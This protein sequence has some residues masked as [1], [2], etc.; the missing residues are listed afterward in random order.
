MKLDEKLTR[1]KYLRDDYRRLEAEAK[2]LK[3]EYKTLELEVMTELEDKDLNRAGNEVAMVA[4]SE[5]NMPTV[6]PIYWQEVR[7]WLTENDYTDCLPRRL[8]AAPI[9]ELWA[10]GI[11]IPHVTPYVKKKLSLTSV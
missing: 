11:E 7:D 6:D 8:N 10:M 2:I 4:L 1:M 5:E 3:E 9:R